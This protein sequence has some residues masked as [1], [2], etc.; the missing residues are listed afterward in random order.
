MA[1]QFVCDTREVR[2]FIRTVKEVIAAAPSVRERLEALRP[3]F[4]ALMADP[5]WLP[6]Q[7]RRSCQAGGMGKGV[8]SWLLYRDSAGTLSLSVLVL[9]PGAATP[10]HDHLAWGLVGLYAGEQDEEVY[11]TSG[12][13]AAGATHAELKLASRNHLRPGSFYELIPPTGD[14]HRVITTGSEPSISLHLL[15]NDVGCVDRHRFDPASGSVSPFRS[16]Y[17]NK[18]CDASTES[19]ENMALAANHDAPSS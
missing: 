14:I 13:V 12:A 7:F 3:A 15:G 2:E 9:S 5:D 8:A 10:V 19:R 4:G 17:S 16:G 11:E 18:E 6:A 1:D